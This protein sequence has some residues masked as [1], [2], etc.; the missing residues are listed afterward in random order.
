MN[1]KG[2]EYVL[3]PTAIPGIWKWQF[4]IGDQIK[5]GKTETESTSWL[6]AAF[7]CAST[8]SSR[9]SAARPLPNST[10]NPGAQFNPPFAIAVSHRVTSP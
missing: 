7:S 8:V 3:A 6:S 9:R 5:T 10:E 2:V 4:R 1:H